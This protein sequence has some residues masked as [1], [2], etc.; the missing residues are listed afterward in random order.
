MILKMTTS[1]TSQTRAALQHDVDHPGTT[2]VLAI[3]GLGRSGSTLIVGALAD[4]QQLVALGEVVHLGPR[5]RS[6]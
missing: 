5:A 1:P 6:R 3:A 4:G 2:R